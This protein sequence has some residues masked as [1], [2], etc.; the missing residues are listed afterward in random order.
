M[1][2]TMSEQGRAMADPGE[3]AVAPETANPER[4]R[5]ALVESLRAKGALRSPAVAEAFAAV[6]RHLFVPD[7]S[8][9]E[10]YRDRFIATKRMAD[11]E[12]I[13][14]SSQPEIMAIML[15]QLDVR[16]G[17]RVLEVGAGSGYN[18]AL[19]ARLV[20]HSGSVTTVDIDDDL[21]A[22]AR[23]HL[24]AAAVTGVRVICADGWAGVADGAPYDRIILTVGAHDL[25]PAW[26]AELATA[27]QQSLGVTRW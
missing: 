6:P 1:T 4:L 26:R 22:S 14:S 7:V 20:S 5:A 2:K 25:S 9:E 17:Q 19:L 12:V 8:V 27:R 15:E 3:A 18:A 10:A 13:S 23:A 21:V 11:G 24:T 16:P